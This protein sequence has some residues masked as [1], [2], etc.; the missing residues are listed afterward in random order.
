VF[1]SAALQNTK[2]SRQQVGQVVPVGIPLKG[3]NTRDAFAA[4]GPEYAISLNNVTVEDFGI[5]TRKGYIEWAINVP[6]SGPVWSLMNYYPSSAVPTLRTAFPMRRTN[7]VQ[8]QL[9]TPSL[10]SLPPAGKLFAARGQSVFDVTAGGTGP[11]VAEAGVGGAGYGAFWTWL[12]FQNIAGSFLLACNWEGGYAIYNG[13]AWSTPIA[14]SG[15]GQIDGI[16]PIKFVFVMV[17]K[18]RVWFIETESTRA[19]YLPVGQITGTVTMFNFGEQFRRGGKLVALANWTV[20]GGIGVD[21]YLIAVSSEGDVVIFKGTDPDV[22]GDFDMVGVWNVG[23]LPAGRRSVTMTGSD[24]H[25]LSQ[26]GVTPVSA[27]FNSVILGSVEQKRLTY[28][29]A[30][31]IAALMDNYSTLDGWQIQSLPAEELLA[32]NVPQGAA[33]DP[34]DMFV[35]KVTTNAWSQFGTMPYTCFV[36]IDDSIFA[37]L[38]DGRVARAF[39]GTLDNRT[40]A[41]PANGDPIQC[42]VTPAY[43]PMGAPGMQK[44]FPLVR[45]T[46]LASTKP[47]I[48]VQMLTDYGPP[49]TPSVPSVPLPPLESAWDTAHWGTARWSAPL[50]QEMRNWIGTRGS[51]FVAAAQLDYRCTRETLLTSIDYFVEP[52]GV[53]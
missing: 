45:P 39:D 24:V 30:P 23:P 36:P 42:Q 27:L 14:G 43:Q 37:G 10:Q 5:K 41:S 29:I 46:F 40:L 28:V 16:D 51:G 12:N 22:A 11:W 2:R 47:T 50:G 1:R 9:Q 7:L 33:E 4:M 31:L 13:S 32:I 35:L 20:D 26:F 18:K 17:W 38:N 3:L 15:A 25:V 52:G 6:G 8:R 19:W 49:V 44:R 21:D 48:S 34:G 53:M